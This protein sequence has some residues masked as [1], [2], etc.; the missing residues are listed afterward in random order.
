MVKTVAWPA[1]VYIV[2]TIVIGTALC[3]AQIPDLRGSRV[4]LLLC[5]AVL[6]S[7]TQIFQVRGLI[8]GSFYNASVLCYSFALFTLGQPEALW[9]AALSN[10]IAWLWGTKGV[11]WYTR[12]FNIGTLVIPLSTATAAYLL[13]NASLG[14]YGFAEALGI[15]AAAMVFTF[16]NHLM[17]G[18][19]HLLV[20]GQSL[21]ASGMFGHVQFMADVTLFMIGAAAALIWPVNPYAVF[22]VVSPLYLIYLTLQVPALRR[23]AESD[24]KTGLFNARYLHQALKKELERAERFDRPLSVIMADLDYL[25]SIN[26]TYGHL[27]GDVVLTG[28]AAL[29]HESVRNYD[30]VARFGG[31][32]FAILLPEAAPE[33]VRPRVESMRA[34]IAAAAFELPASATPLKVTMSFGIAGRQRPGQTAVEILQNADKA[35]YQAKQAGRNR[36]CVFTETEQS[37]EGNSSGPRAEDDWPDTRVVPVNSG[38]ARHEIA[39][40]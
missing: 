31:D 33:H 5:V 28:I 25:R 15:L 19:L 13:I 37:S 11:L 24:A 36:V 1:R 14:Q 18:I 20:D 10:V 3:L 16:V 29:L 21:V 17:V 30:V 8:P 4:W 6:A 32:E 40:G 26:N 23:R 27:A 38:P 39:V 22:L 9:V 2:V 7:L 12:I 35:L 34:A